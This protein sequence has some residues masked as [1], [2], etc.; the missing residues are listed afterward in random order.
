[1]DVQIKRKTGKKLILV[2]V[3]IVLVI[4]IRILITTRKD[5]VRREVDTSIM[6][7]EIPV[8]VISLNSCIHTNVNA[9]I[10]YILGDKGNIYVLCCDSKDYYVELWHPE[11]WADIEVDDLCAEGKKYSYA[12]ALD[13]E[14]N[15]YV[16]DKEYLVKNTEFSEYQKNGLEWDKQEDWGIQRLE[17]I[18]KISGIF[19]AYSR[20]VL[21]TEQGDAYI[22]NP[23]D[24]TNP[25]LEDM[26]LVEMESEILRAASLKDELLVLDSNN[27][28]WSIENGT[29][30]FL[31]ENV[32]N[33]ITG[34][35]GFVL[36]MMNA[37]NE[38]Y[39]CNVYRLQLEQEKT[40]YA[41]KYE[42]SEMT[43]EGNILS[44]SVSGETAVVYV[45][46]GKSYRW[47]RKPRA[48]I[49]T[50]WL[51]MYTLCDKVYEQ[52]VEVDLKEAEYYMLIGPDIVYVDNHNR[53]YV[54]LQKP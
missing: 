39:V 10:A 1:M 20:F 17:G 11:F 53:M 49:S 33:I 35:K 28:L 40:Q 7:D 13:R 31:K 12:L 25:K 18:P 52:P 26:E 29:K 2:L 9:E 23:E 14:G 19:A 36:Q 5:E 34:G 37:R 54:L 24:T 3:L 48:F 22:W 32:K 43:F 46:N 50:K 47:G 8:K 16:W 27:V 4:C 42:V 44:L 38:V 30:K 15:V 51:S 41:D 21:V 6:G 45:D